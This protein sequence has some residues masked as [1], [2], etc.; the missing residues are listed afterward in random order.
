MI[1]MNKISLK[2]LGLSYSHS[3]TG[4]YLIVLSEEGTN[5]KLPII[6]K[7]N[8]AQY[9]ALKIENVEMST[10]L[11]HDLFKTMI[12]GLNGN[13]NYVDIHSVVEGI[14]YCRLSI[15]TPDGNNVEID[16]S[17][18]DA[19]AIS[20]SLNI[21][22]YTN[23]D[24]LGSAGI[25]MNDDGTVDESQ[26]TSSNAPRKAS[27]SAESLEK[28]LK[29]AIANDEFEVAAQLRDKINSLKED[30]ETE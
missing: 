20:L 3:Q 10:P 19:I 9:I 2:I 7:P 28:L 4:S 14:F 1:N 25:F 5:R 29:K 12:E 15:S 16:L 21:P 11:T 8:D 30:K 13:A 27:T 24:V 22:I 26:Q 18:G 23:D 6:I 17:I